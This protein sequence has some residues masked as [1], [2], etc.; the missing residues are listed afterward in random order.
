M[1]VLGL[2]IGKDNLYAHLRQNDIAHS[3]G[4]IP[5][6]PAGLERLLR[7]TRKHHVEL[8]Q[9]HVIMEATGMYWEHSAHFF[10]KIGCTVSVVNPTSIK[11]FA[12]A[13]LSRGK[14]DAM[15]AQVIALYGTTMSPKPWA[16]PSAALNALKQLVRERVA[17]TE[18]L[19][20][21]RNRLHASDRRHQENPVIINM[22][23][24]RIAL[25]KQ[26]VLELEDA[27]RDIVKADSSLH[28]AFNLLISIPGYGFIT[29]VSVLAE[30]DGFALMET[31]KQ[32]SAYAGIAPAPFQSGSS[33]YGRGR[34]SKTGNGR[35]RRTAYLAA[36]SI[37][38]HKGSLGEFYRRL[39]DEG[40]PPKVA[41]IALAH[42]LLRIGL[43]IV[44]SGQVYSEAYLRPVAI[45]DETIDSRAHL[46][47]ML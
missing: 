40:K 45:K 23:K 39:R 29:A 33:V 26:Q 21:D 7:W 3:L 4:D 43:A 47:P 1:F 32:I 36:L 30:T 12:R 46:A 24:A 28:G 35:L 10:H 38:R 27:I 8:T 44:K 15:D 14:T 20:M 25:L 5:N 18:T 41:L 42:K 16:P 9:L 2:D 37:T 31:G 11:Y 17:L 22:L 13:K 34:I 6:T 19:T